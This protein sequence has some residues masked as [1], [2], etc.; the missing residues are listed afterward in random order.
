MQG[1]ATAPEP[2]PCNPSA[3]AHEQI[4]ADF[5][6]V[7]P[8]HKVEKPPV[9]DTKSSSFSNFWSRKP[10]ASSATASPSIAWL[11]A[12]ES[13]RSSIEALVELLQREEPA[14]LSDPL[15]AAFG[16]RDRG[17]LCYMRAG[18]VNF[19][20]GLART[21][22]KATSAFRAQMDLDSPTLDVMQAIEAHALRPHWPGSFPM[23]A[24]D[25][26][27]VLFCRAGLIKPKLLTKEGDEAL[28]YCTRARAFQE[29]PPHRSCI[30]ARA[31]TGH[32]RMSSQETNHRQHV[33]LSRA[34]LQS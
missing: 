26:C 7:D 12:T 32:T 24:P 22:L 6:P 23:I 19:D 5:V 17:M 4:A 27:P 1:A 18:D 29:C 25:G 21:R 14:L 8:P 3:A 20:L 28:S 33:R 10:P 30:F 9:E 31:P 16:G 11:N 34:C 2:A 15:F 13:E